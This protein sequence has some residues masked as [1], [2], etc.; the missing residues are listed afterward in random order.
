MKEDILEQMVDEYLQHKGYFTQHNLKFRPAKDHVDYVAQADAVHS[1]VDV[2]GIHPLMQ[3]PERVVVV[4]CKSWQQGFSPQYWSD[5]IA[6]N[7]KVNGREAWMAFR[8][9]ARPKWAQAF[10]A[11]VE[12]ATGAKAFT[13]VT[14]VTRLTAQAD[15][16]AWEQHPEFR[17]SLN[18]NPIRILTFDDMLSEL[19]P[20]IN[21]TVASSQLGRLLQLI[22]ASGW[23]LASRNENG[24]SLV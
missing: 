19:F 18:G 5:A 16:T 23:A 8:E 12:R 11:E 7:K 9:L 6:K 21:Q 22:K 20:T 4:S 14:A 24:P 13:Y 15:R 17:Q 10:R 3:G 1:D 2:I